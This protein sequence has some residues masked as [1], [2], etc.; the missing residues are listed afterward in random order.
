[1]LFFTGLVNFFEIFVKKLFTS[2]KFVYICKI[3][4]LNILNYGTH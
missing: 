3:K 1:M 4:V 2:K